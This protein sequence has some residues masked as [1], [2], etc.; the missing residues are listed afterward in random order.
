MEFYQ[1][2]LYLH[3][4]HTAR[5]QPS[6]SSTPTIVSN[7]FANSQTIF[8]LRFF[9]KKQTHTV[10]S[11]RPN[12]VDLSY[13]GRTAKLHFGLARQQEKV[14]VQL[15]SQIVS[16]FR[17][18]NR[19]LKAL[20]NEDT[21]LRT[22]CCRYKCFPVCPRAQ[23]L[24]RTQIL[25]PGHKKCLILFR[26]IL[27]PQ[28]MLPSP[29]LRSPRNIMGNNVSATMC[30]RLSG[31]LRIYDGDGKD[32]AQLKMC[33]YFTLEFRIYQELSRVSVVI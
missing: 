12:I 5:L 24:L 22:H 27:C 6:K 14:Q 8:R 33:L 7:I 10:C 16:T 15:D 13:R 9:S 20:A 31:P 11:N 21:L 28:Q 18:H 2:I 23:H 17:R 19:N 30:P 26:N 29:S 1:K 4:S 25:C 3:V 32:D